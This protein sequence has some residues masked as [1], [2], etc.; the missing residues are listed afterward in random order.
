MAEL[1]TALQRAK[2][3]MVR[4]L[5]Q[6]Q[7]LMNINIEIFTYCK[8]LEGEQSRLESGMQNSEGLSASL[9]LASAIE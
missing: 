9:A 2:Q 3:D 8:P 7:E 6:N 1:E 4:Q 5:L